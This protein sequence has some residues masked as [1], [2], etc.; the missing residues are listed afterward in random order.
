M[1]NNTY[2]LSIAVRERIEDRFKQAEMYRLAKL[3]QPEPKSSTWGPFLSS[4]SRE[5]LTVVTAFIR[6]NSR[7]TVQNKPTVVE[8]SLVS[9]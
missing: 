7:R 5:I 1:N 3:V 9:R 6:H 2:F 8:H 4:K